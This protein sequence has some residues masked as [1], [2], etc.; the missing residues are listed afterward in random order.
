MPDTTAQIANKNQPPT[1]IAVYKVET[2]ESFRVKSALSVFHRTTKRTRKHGSMS[3]PKTMR[4]IHQIL[5][6]V[7]CVAFSWLSMMVVHELGHVLGATCTGARVDKVVLHPLAISRTDVSENRHPLIVVWAGPVLGV[8]LPLAGLGAFVLA[9]LPGQYFVRFFA[10][11]CL[12]A[13]GAYIGFGS[14]EQIGDAGDMLRHGSPAWWLWV[15]GTLTVPLGFV[16]WNGLGSHF[17]F[18]A[19][20]GVVNRSAAYLSATLLALTVLAELCLSTN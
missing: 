11:F 2:F 16:L 8:L 6:I 10:G 20:N 14:F 5:L 19:A 3:G 13:N 7:T 12:V 1:S 15:F 4:R 18:G 9:K 17:G